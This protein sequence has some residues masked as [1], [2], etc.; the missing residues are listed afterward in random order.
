MFILAAVGVII[1]LT[2]AFCPHGSDN[3]HE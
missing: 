2:M 3:D 1:M